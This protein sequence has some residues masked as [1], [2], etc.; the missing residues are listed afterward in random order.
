MTKKILYITSLLFIIS[1]M[2]MPFAMP[3]CG[4]NNFHMGFQAANSFCGHEYDA[5]HISFMRGLI[6]I[7][8]VALVIVFAEIIFRTKLFSLLKQVPANNQCNFNYLNKQL[9]L[10]RMKPFDTLL[11]AYSSGIIQPKIFCL[12]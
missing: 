2:V 9:I 11:L 4:M 10:G 6:F 8:L 3:F 5:G 7:G 1:A 12:K